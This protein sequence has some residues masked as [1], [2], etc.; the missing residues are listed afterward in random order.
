MDG[1]YYLR[2]G[3]K[4]LRPGMIVVH[5]H[6]MHTKGMPLG[7]NGFRAWQQMP[8]KDRVR[9]RCGW[10]GIEHYRVRGLGGKSFTW[11]EIAK[12]SGMPMYA[13][14]GRALPGKASRAGA[15]PPT[16]LRKAAG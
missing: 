12:A 4:K 1:S 15:A 5:N 16:V 8:A 7:L 6:V 2:P 10:H 14:L 9:C 13:A 3:F 11:D